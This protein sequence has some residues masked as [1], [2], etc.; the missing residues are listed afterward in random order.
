MK[1]KP[2]MKT[3]L[4]RTIKMKFKHIILISMILLILTATASADK[5][6]P[7][8]TK[9][10]FEKNGVPYNEPVK[11][12]VACY[13]YR[14]EIRTQEFKDYLSGNYE[15]KDPKTYNM[16]EVFS[17]SAT[18]EN[19]GT[20]IFEPFY[21]NYRVIDHCTLYGETNGQKFIIENIGENPVPDCI[22]REDLT[23]M[24]CYDS[25][26]CIIETDEYENCREKQ[27]DLIKKNRDSCQIFIEEYDGNQTHSINGTMISNDEG[28]WILTKEYRSCI[29]EAVKTEYNCSQYYEYVPCE[30]Y[31]DPDGNKIYR[32]CNLYYTIPTDNA[33]NII[34]MTEEGPKNNQTTKENTKSEENES[35]FTIILKFLGLK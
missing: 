15:K 6:I 28:K 18:A 20:E 10:F 8:S 26:T 7:T 3:G 16:T 35:I 30:D 2:L 12:N 25:D 33:G 17:Y 14:V 29:E 32:D 11:F 4:K 34:E 19:Y 21:L 23:D 31:C 22:Y 13:G 5:V 1:P 27:R 24:Q 9:V